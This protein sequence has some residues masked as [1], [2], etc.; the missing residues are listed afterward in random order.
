MVENL[1]NM[2]KDINIQTPKFNEHKTQ[3]KKRKYHKEIFSWQET[4][5]N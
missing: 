2:E 5:E 1:Q 3:E 4:P